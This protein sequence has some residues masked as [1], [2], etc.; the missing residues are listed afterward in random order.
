MIGT[1]EAQKFLGGPFD[2]QLGLLGTVAAT[3]PLFHPIKPRQ[4]TIAGSYSQPSVHV[5][6]DWLPRAP[7]LKFIELACSTENHESVQYGRQLNE[8]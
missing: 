2:A 5:L 7:A 3:Q 4:L 6:K 1:L 8:S